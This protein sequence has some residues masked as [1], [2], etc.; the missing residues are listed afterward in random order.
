M[1]KTGDE[2]AHVAIKTAIA[3]QALWFPFYD[4][5]YPPHE[6]ATDWAWQHLSLLT[7]RGTVKLPAPQWPPYDP[8]WIPLVGAT[9]RWS[10]VRKRVM[11][12]D[13]ADAERD[14]LQFITSTSDRP[15]PVRLFDI[16]GYNGYVPRYN[17]VSDVRLSATVEMLSGAG[18][19]ELAV[20]K[21]DDY[22][23]VRLH[24]DGQ[25]TLEHAAEIDGPRERWSSTLVEIPDRP[26]RLALGHADYRVT[27]EWDGHPVLVSSV[28]HYRVPVAT[29]RQREGRPAPVTLRV[30]AER[31]VATLAH[32]AIERDVHYIGAGYGDSCSNGTLGS[33]I[34]LPDD[35]YFVCGDNSPFSRDSRRWSADELGPHLRPAYER[36]DY[37]IGTVPADQMIGR[38]FL[39]YWPGFLSLTEKGGNILPD[40]GRVRW[41]D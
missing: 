23:F 35:A 34:M 9:S 3:Q 38:A 30:A 39:V 27:V 12:F 6:P 13:G 25:L 5:D 32:I 24:A 29:A 18:Y 37:Q 26:V 15:E 1:L 11:R 16:Y 14:E 10:D 28:E 8:H 41:I 17:E 7:S 21:Y 19:V 36:G 20:S 40:L 33:P 4:Q 2:A 31:I 22:F